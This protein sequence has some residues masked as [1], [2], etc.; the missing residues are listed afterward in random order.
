MGDDGAVAYR[1]G[2]GTNLDIAFVADMALFGD[3]ALDVMGVHVVSAHAY[4]I[5][6]DGF[7]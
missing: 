2:S 4:G 1:V 7:A 6:D 5:G 3:V